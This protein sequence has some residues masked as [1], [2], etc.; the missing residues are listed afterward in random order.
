ML[1]LFTT[2]NV[3]TI[4]AD[5]PVTGIVLNMDKSEIPVLSLDDGDTM[6]VDY[7]VTPN[8]ATN[9][10]VTYSF[11][12]VGEEKMAEFEMDGNL[13]IPKEH[14]KAKVTVE[15]VDGGFRDSFV[16]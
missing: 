2:T 5:V 10:E 4:V 8:G 16:V 1:S 12:P 14:G 15:T 6:R 11:S 9:K 13:L 7:S 3:V